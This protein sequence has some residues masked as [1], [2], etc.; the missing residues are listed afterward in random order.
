VV[1]FPQDTSEPDHV[2]RQAQSAMRM[3]EARGR[4]QICFYTPEANARVGEKL[5]MEAALRSALDRQELS[6]VYQPQVD[7]SNG[8]VIG[9]EA[10]A[11]WHH[12]ELGEV[13]ATDFIA[14]AEETGMIFSLGLWSLQ[15]ACEM[16]VRWKSRGL[17]PLRMAVNLSPR[18]LL[19]ADI[20]SAIEAILMQTG[21]DPTQ[22]TI[23]IG[24][25]MLMENLDQVSATLRSL[26]SIGIE[27]A[28]D[29]FGVG[30]SSL[31]SLRRLPIDMIKIDRS[32]VPDVTADTE[33]VSITHAIITLA[34]CLN[35]KVLAV[36]VESD[37]ELALLVAN[38]CDQMQGFFFS[39]PLPEDDLVSLMT[40]G[41]CLPESMLGRNAHKRTLLIVDDEENIVSS[42][43]RLLRKDGYNIVT[44][45]S[46][47]QGLQRMAECNVDVILS[48]QRMPGMT[49]VEF[50][51]RAKELYP[52]TIR[53][54]LSGYTELQSITDAINEGAIY[55][56][57]TK[58]WD[59]ARVRAHIQEAFH[60]K[61]MA[62]ENR[63]LDREVQEANRE[64]AEVNGRLQRLL[65][66]QREQIHRE[67]TSLIIARE[68][69]ENIPAP[70]I[71]L[72]PSGTVAFMNPDAEA[73][74]EGS[75]P[76]LGLHI[77]EVQS[78]Q[79]LALWQAADGQHHLIAL[80]GQSFSGVCRAMTGEARTRGALMVLTPLDE[81]RAPPHQPPAGRS[82]T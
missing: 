45:N 67:E 61:E 57:L 78:G 35:M 7:L 28:L 41:R 18:Q 12:P 1:I 75:A 64:L 43:R 19:Q 5:A 82:P 3:A 26:K 69:L 68:V 6:L 81:A 71:G 16:A 48:D 70:V 74:F 44:A 46:G 31:T 73:L 29:D 14:L 55:K 20:A 76:A 11:R 54:V 79:L 49:G 42:L 22:L 63:R 36:G 27:I 66:S 38:Q 2:L 56:F 21:L 37:G 47:P 15:S 53:M 25:G 10:L 24:E 30:Y 65:E 80:M 72:D 59:D 13:P 39:K 33:D 50:L 40:E 8:K 77:G 62:D 34:H 23:E 52:H 32:L 9:V 58:P 60:Q 4:N 17:P 51:R